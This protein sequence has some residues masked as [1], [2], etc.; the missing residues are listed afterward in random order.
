MNCKIVALLL[1]TTCAGF[2]APV[3]A[4][5]YG[6]APSNRPA[7]DAPAAE[8]GQSADVEAPPIA[9]RDAA[10]TVDTQRASVSIGGTAESVSQSG[11][12][13]EIAARNRLFA[14]H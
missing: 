13:A 9:R 11:A 3:L 8:L 10:E 4:S 1:A 6:P 5:N 14:H 12:P 7:L 2:A